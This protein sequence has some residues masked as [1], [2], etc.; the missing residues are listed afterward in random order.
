M[1]SAFPQLRHLWSCVHTLGVEGG[2][3]STSTLNVGGSQR[4]VVLPECTRLNAPRLLRACTLV[5]FSDVRTTRIQVE[6]RDGTIPP[7]GR[8][9]V[10]VRFL[11][12]LPP[13]LSGFKGEG[14][15]QEPLPSAFKGKGCGCL[16]EIAKGE[17]G[18]EDG[19]REKRERYEDDTPCTVQAGTFTIDFEQQK[20]FCPCPRTTELDRQAGTNRRAVV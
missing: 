8:Q 13:R 7:Y 15:E 5:H 18:G 3:I 11:P 4:S 16:R 20:S 19:E 6:P 9:K 1:T 10:A 2:L 14:C 12:T 17:T